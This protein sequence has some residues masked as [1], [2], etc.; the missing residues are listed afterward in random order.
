MDSNEIKNA[1]KN[2][3]TGDGTRQQEM[4]TGENMQEPAQRL[5]G[6]YL[7]NWNERMQVPQSGKNQM[8]DTMRKGN[9]VPYEISTD[10][11]DKMPTLGSMKK[12]VNPTATYIDDNGDKKTGVTAG[13]AEETMPQEAAQGTGELSYWDSMRDYYQK[14]YEEQTAANNAAAANAAAQ[15]LENTNRQIDALKQQYA[16]TNKELYRNYMNQQRV[17]PQQLASQGYS[18]GMSESAR[19]RLGTGYQ[20]ALN[21]NQQALA[22]EQTALNAAYTQAQYE[23]QA[24]ADAANA[25]ALQQKYGYI[26]QLEGDRYKTDEAQKAERA[27]NLAAVGD[28]S[29]FLELGYDQTQVD[30]MTRVWLKEHPELKNTW[31]KGNPETAKRLGIKRSTSS[32]GSGSG[33]NGP[34]KGDYVTAYNKL[35]EAGDE[36]GAANVLKEYTGSSAYNGADLGAAKTTSEYNYWAN[37]AG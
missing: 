9:M 7:Q 35:L 11:T 21:N 10:K 32:G 17:L 19:L 29:G 25:Q 26:A 13:D 6:M 20:E 12:N 5:T 16:G 18:G 1:Y 24:A 37:I 3:Y 28:F 27:Q 8:P 34:T 2:A 33:G 36:Q 4:K 30:Y 14:M 31:I 15:A 22:N 23:A